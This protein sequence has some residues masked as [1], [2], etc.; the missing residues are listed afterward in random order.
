MLV[1][2]SIVC[3]YTAEDD[4]GL[5]AAF[6]DLL[7][8]KYELVERKLDLAV[9]TAVFA[10]DNLTAGQDNYVKMYVVDTI[11][12]VTT[13]EEYVSI[14]D[15]TP[16]TVNLFTTTSHTPG[17]ITADVNVTDDS[18]AEVFFPPRSTGFLTWTPS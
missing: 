4:V 13:R 3:S 15:F 8:Q 10:F 9:S 16:P 2:T 12:N 7:T 17:H 14:V 5:R 6:Y 18:G 1:F 11:E